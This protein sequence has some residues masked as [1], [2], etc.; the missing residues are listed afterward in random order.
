MNYSLPHEHRTLGGLPDRGD[1]PD[2]DAGAERAVGVTNGDVLGLELDR[3]IRGAIHADIEALR[4]SVRQIDA[5]LRA[6][7]YQMR[8]RNEILFLPADVL[9]PAAPQNNKACGEC[10]TRSSS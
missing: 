4:Q 10:L 7:V 8:L 5:N 6:A 3:A 2:A 1:W 9:R